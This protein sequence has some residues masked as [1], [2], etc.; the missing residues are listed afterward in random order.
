MINFNLVF[1]IIG[2]LILLILIA[3]FIQKLHHRFYLKRVKKARKYIYQVYQNKTIPKKP[4]RD[5]FLFKTLVDLENQ[6][7]LD[8]AEKNQLFQL[9]NLSK[10]TNKFKRMTKSMFLFKR[11]KG[12]RYLSYIKSEDTVN[13][14][15]KILKK[16][17]FN[18]TIFYTI[19]ALIDVINQ[20]TFDL[21]LNKLKKLNMLYLKRICTIFSN[22]F[23][24]IQPFIKAKTDSQ[25]ERIIYLFSHI[26]KKYHSCADD[27]F[28]DRLIERYIKSPITT[29][30][31]TDIRKNLLE[32]LLLRSHAILKTDY[33]LHHEDPFV[34][35]YGFKS[36]AQSKTKETF[37]QLLEL[38]Q[39]YLKQ[40][41]DITEAI[42]DNFNVK[43]L[44]FYIL[45]NPKLFEWE[46]N[47]LLL[48]LLSNH[49]STLILELSSDNAA[50]V[51]DWIKQ[52]IQQGYT[53]SIITFINQ[54]KKQD[55]QDRVF[56]IL[57]PLIKN[58]K[59]VKTKFE[60]YVKKDILK[61]Y[62]L[63]KKQYKPKQ[64][65]VMPFELSK[66]LWMGA[67]LI[68][69]LLWYPSLSLAKHGLQILETPS[70]NII[71][72]LVV[73]TNYYLVVYFFIANMIYF[74]L[75]LLSVY[76][77]HKQ[78]TLWNLKPETLLYE[79]GLLPA[80]SII[81]PAYN[82]E[83]SIISNIQ[84]LLNLKY[85]NYEVIVVNDGSKDHTLNVVI[86]E[87]ALERADPAY[88]IRL[89]TKSVRGVYTTPDIPNLIVIDK[90]NGGKADALNVGIN[91][92]KHPFICG[93]DADSI[94]EQEALLRLLSSTLDRSKPPV[95]LGGNIIPAND[96]II[97]RGHIEKVQFPKSNLTRFQAIEYLRAFT[98]G[99][100]G[101]S[102]LQSL[103]IISG[104]F[105]VFNRK[106]I[107]NVGGYITSSGELNKDSVGED[108]ELV[109]RL[110]HQK[111]KKKE[112]YYI[113]YIYHAGCHTELPSD[114][115]SL[116]K[117]R[118]RWHRGLIDILSYH[119]QI[120]LN[121]RYKQVGFLAMPYFY[122]F[123]VVGPFIETI[124]YVALL[125]S[126][127]FGFLDP[128]IVLRY[129]ILTILIGIVV[130]LM[131]LF[132]AENVTPRTS[133]K[134][135]LYLIIFAILENFGYRQLI[136]FHRAYSFFTALFEKGTWG[137]Q[138]RK[139]LEQ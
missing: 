127:I 65:E 138:K 86:K 52:L 34:R 98:S 75:L 133:K 36:L 48:K 109:V 25:D 4:V 13:Y 1:L 7:K 17:K 100:I 3:I 92:A 22:H 77:A 125:S 108:M 44:L 28:F 80:I 67:I 24:N 114:C 96:S 11:I 136:S 9:I 121:P 66:V 26:S 106:D 45:D 90:E 68:I 137:E 130:S 56:D 54:N 95:A 116:L 30:L 41:D 112:P 16:A 79:N 122:I 14:L 115:K 5:Y 74:L 129:F 119:R 126:F 70:L 102:I 38:S 89:K 18:A 82:E 73:D 12:I 120:L 8:N 131:S 57:M 19:Y 47:D 105:G 139:G 117:Q 99:R 20:E 55:I 97:D 107:I 110:T 128:L 111:L 58:N 39:T 91:K 83:V 85:P 43:E 76:G 134:D 60:L 50:L 88:K 21:I 40:L 87:F 72:T 46:T 103:L 63:S 61:K 10:L 94:L 123:E 101:W 15:E 32:G 93:I 62:G 64:K 6:I 29:E 31:K 135:V 132:V 104:A 35:V 113:A 69:T 118:N 37:F 49:S 78:N 23:G 124:G 81:A 84:S 2:S 42:E 59:S 53:A 71:K 51:K 33:V 27:A